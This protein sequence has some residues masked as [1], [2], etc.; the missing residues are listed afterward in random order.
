MASARGQ[1]L[2][3]R[4]RAPDEGYVALVIL[5]PPALEVVHCS[6]EGSAREMRGN[7]RGDGGEWEVRARGVCWLECG[8]GGEEVGWYWRE[9]GGVGC[10]G[11]CSG[12]KPR[13]RVAGR[14][15]AGESASVEERARGGEGAV[16]WC[17]HPCPESRRRRRPHQYILRRRRRPS[18]RR[19]SIAKSS[20]GQKVGRG[21][22]GR[23]LSLT[24]LNARAKRRQ[25]SQQ[26]LQQRKSYTTG[27]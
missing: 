1:E 14:G 23:R 3:G 4:R 22:N 6:E 7:E 10:G 19:R 13:I 8:R 11:V 26:Q 16:R 27:R 9:K 17:G 5:V 18:N 12:K 21:A 2:A 24:V 20:T 15:R 25:D